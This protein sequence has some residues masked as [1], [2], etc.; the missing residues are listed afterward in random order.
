MAAQSQQLLLAHLHLFNKRAATNILFGSSSWNIASSAKHRTSIVCWIHF[1]SSLKHRI[2]SIL[3]QIWNPPTCRKQKLAR[4]TD[5]RPT[6]EHSAH[7]RR[8]ARTRSMPSTGYFEQHPGSFSTRLRRLPWGSVTKATFTSPNRFAYVCIYIY[9]C[10]YVC[11][12]VYICVYICI[13]V[14]IYMYMYVVRCTCRAFGELVRKITCRSL[15]ISQHCNHFSEDS[16]MYNSKTCNM[17]RTR[18]E[19]SLCGRGA[20]ASLDDCRICQGQRWTSARA[21]SSVSA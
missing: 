17:K 20:A 16:H 8:F 11:M 2:L 1:G 18:K 10:I 7:A 6:F 3:A 9:V 21:H 12:C 15:C 19:Y 4:S 13:C 5:S 14:Y